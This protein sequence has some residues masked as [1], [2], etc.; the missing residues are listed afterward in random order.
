[1]NFTVDEACVDNLDKIKI[2]LNSV[3]PVSYPPTFYKNIKSGKY[4]GYVGIVQKRAIGCII[5]EEEICTIQILALGVLVAYRDQGVATK[6][7]DE[8][9]MRKKDVTLH[10]QTNNDVAVNF[11]KKRGFIVEECVENYYKRTQCTNAYKMSYK[12]S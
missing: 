3:L 9:L 2:I 10:V 12:V 11:Y 8:C 1:M 7:L 6:L 5:L 4:S